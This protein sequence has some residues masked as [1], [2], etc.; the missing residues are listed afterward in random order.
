MVKITIEAMQRI[1]EEK[2]IY[3]S[4]DLQKH[5]AC[6]HQCI[7]DNLKAV[8][9]F[10]SFTHNSKYYTLAAIPE[11]DD[12]DIWFFHDSVIGE[13]GFTKHKT[14]ANLILSL[15]NSSQTGLTAREITDIM[16]IR[17]SNQLNGLVKKSKIR[18]HKLENTTYYFSIDEAQYRAQ[19]AN[20]TDADFLSPDEPCDSVSKEQHYKHRIK[21]LT[22]SREK[23]RK[24]SNEKQKTIRDHLIV[25]RDL[26][27]SRDKW[28]HTAQNYKSKVKQLSV[29]IANIKKNC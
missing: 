16:K 21:R 7:W 3:S 2:Y 5:F 24:R 9:Y 13:I 11:F 1:F 10:S 28:K 22:D 29:E 27:R 14:A 12:N 26:T 6:T 8:G 25:I 4:E 19:Y 15:I 18:Q 17:V 23:W 20:L